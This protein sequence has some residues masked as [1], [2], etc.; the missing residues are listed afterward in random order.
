MERGLL[1]A[2]QWERWHVDGWCLLP[3]ILPAD[4]VA[5]AQVDLAELFPSTESV[6]ERVAVGGTADIDLRWDTAKPTFPFPGQSLNRLALHERIIGLAEEL[7]ETDQV[8]MY[9]GIASAKYSGGDPDYEQLLHVDYGNHTLVVPRADA[10]YQHLELFI[11]L[12]DV[13]PETAATR[14][15]SRQLT[16][17]IPVERMYLHLTDYASIY[18]QEVSAS[19]PAGSVLAYR[20]DVY[21]RGTSLIAEGAARFLLHVAYKPVATDWLGYHA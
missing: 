12:S 13:T 5:A 18:E 21:H 7:L 6:A 10:G 4:E 17:D 14:V 20:P 11:Y 16:A 8:R 19:G 2:E 15:V 9:Q 3:N 1:D